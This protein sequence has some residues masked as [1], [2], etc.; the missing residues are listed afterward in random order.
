M[1]RSADALELASRAPGLADALAA[2]ARTRCTGMGTKKGESVSASVVCCERE[3]LRARGVD[4]DWAARLVL[5]WRE[6]CRRASSA[7]LAE[8]R[9]LNS[10]DAG[11]KYASQ[12]RY[13]RVAH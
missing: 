13:Q 11:E 4:L 9:Q 12:R 3:A 2:V 7:R 10:L 8:M 6:A 5:S 1:L